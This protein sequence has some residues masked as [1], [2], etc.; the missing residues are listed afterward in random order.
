MEKNGK[1]MKLSPE[2]TERAFNVLAKE[3][4]H[5]GKWHATIFFRCSG[6]NSMDK[7]TLIKLAKEEMGGV[8]YGLGI[9]DETYEEFNERIIREIT[10]LKEKNV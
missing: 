1:T 3:H 10:D 2:E 8:Y 7:D 9:N 4:L 5:D 6:F